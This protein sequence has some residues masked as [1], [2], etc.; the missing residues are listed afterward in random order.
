MFLI[1]LHTHTSNALDQH[2]LL[3]DACITLTQGSKVIFDY[4]L[5]YVKKNIIKYNFQNLSTL[6]VNLE[7]NES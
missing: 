1:M 7:L 3:T 6:L 2:I 4:H 5:C